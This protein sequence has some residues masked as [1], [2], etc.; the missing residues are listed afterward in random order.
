MR[1]ST[2][3]L[4]LLIP[5][6]LAGPSTTALA[7]DT[8]DT[9]FLHEP[10]IG[11]GRIAFVYAD[12]LWTAR[13]DGSDVRRL[14]SHPGP[15]SS[16]YISPDGKLVAFTGTYDGN[17]DVY[18][19]PIEGGEPTR[20]TWH[21]GP[22][23]AVG[24]TPEG[25]VLFRSP[26]SVFSNRYTQFFS[27]SPRGGA[28]TQLPIP[29]GFRAACSP[30]GKYIAYTP[31][32]EPFRQWKNYRGGSHS[33]VWVMKLADLSVEIIPQPE[34]RCN[35]TYPMWLGDSVYFLS[36]RSG[37]FNLFSYDPASKAIEPLTRHDD[38]PV[39]AASA[40]KDSIVYEQG[41]HIWAFDPTSKHANR[42]KIGVAADLVETRP[43]HASGAKFVRA[44]D[45]SPTGQ[46]AA[47]EFRGEILT[48]PAKKGDVR[49]LTHT[50]GVH[51]R[52]PAW[53]PDGKKL[54]YF[55]DA[56]GEYA[57]H[58]AP[59]D[60]KGEAK[61][62]PIQG[63]GF[64][65]RPSWSPDGNKLAF[66][67][68][69]RTYSYIDLDSGKVTPIA[70]EAVYGPVNTMSLAWS[71]DSKWVAYT[72]TN[73]AYFQALK[74][75]SLDQAKSYPITDG[76]AEVAEPTFDASGKYLYFLASTDAGPVK[77]WFDQS[78][79][80]I[81]ATHSVFLAVLAKATPNPLIKPNDEEADKP[82]EDEKD[83]D[84]DKDKKKEGPKPTVIDVDGIESRVI[85]LPIPAGNLANLAGGEE[86]K[87]YYV[88]RVGMIPG[89][90]GEPFA[91]TPSLVRFD[92]KPREEEVLAEKVDDF[93]LSDDRK[94]VLYHSKE[95]WGI[96]DAGK[97]AVGKD[98]LPIASISV[99]VDP[100]AEWAEMLREA[101][102]INRD[103][104]YDPKM[105]G[106][107]W[108]AMLEKYSKLLPEVPSRAD[109]NRVIR[110][111]CSELAVG[112]SYLNG[113]DLAYEPKPTPVGL[114]GADYE[115][116]EGRYR[117]KKVY[118]GLNWDPDLKAPLVAP[119]VD[120]KPGEFLLAVDG[121]DVTPAREV[122]AAFED[123]VGRRVEIKVGP[124]ADGTGSR[125]VVVE[126]IATEAALR[127]RDW[128]EGNLRKVRERTNGRVAYVYVPNTADLGHAYFKRYFFP[129]ADK[130]G[131]IVDERFN[132]GGSVADY[133]IDILRR[134]VSSYWAM[135]HGAPIRTPGAAILGP[136]VM[137]IDETA[138]SGGDMLP[139]MFR[140]FQ[141]GTLI[142]KRTWGG[143][144]GILG[145]PTLL[146]GARVTAP[147]LAFYTDDGWRV[148][149]EGVPP[150]VEVEQWPADVMAGKD[151]QL[152]KAI[153]S[154][155]ESLRKDPPKT[156]EP[157]ARPVRVRRKADV[158]AG[159]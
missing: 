155:L 127:N 80:D 61:A 72:L 89:K 78:N 124:N 149:N 107:D 151:P 69:S 63:P 55:S 35:D 110:G 5:L 153:E 25:Q 74:L 82:K 135:R 123:K 48:V 85:A 102:R 103:Y 157:P 22:D 79:A 2:R 99:K 37:E 115:V 142:G 77:Q 125:V 30:D 143:L 96:A 104:F 59:Q 9:S 45:I 52:S 154:V 147:D 1:R 148:E 136:K 53:S 24:F 114:L 39:E 68:N 62:Y 34:G 118:G 19:V 13:V 67:D 121:E 159:G 88:R 108:P 42:L 15:E 38:F 140:R 54:A 111:M 26:R 152:D 43:R 120:V 47:I 101:W 28:P 92:L 119:G 57:L 122:Y 139:W 76:L 71:P 14:T 12:D 70:S 50:T 36:D 27:V 97:F 93:R 132:G 91:G 23:A 10:A 20:L 41:G 144:V 138:G 145:F 129:Q 146:D 58:I 116:A 16:P 90:T 128:V 29:N 4:L 64:Y 156:L 8:T 49:N 33:R 66:T 46:R 112:H 75:Y 141:L 3:R 17:P 130:D 126:P 73:K 94:K 86:G 56:S 7:V 84:K 65:E 60:G 131:I 44:A 95:T 100:R 11:G 18:V 51:E 6:A 21:P 106:A 105:H 31:L 109:L 158:A 133:Y 98:A 87:V 32:N 117:F 113:G 40:G 83:K 134:P 137:L 81:Q 150:D